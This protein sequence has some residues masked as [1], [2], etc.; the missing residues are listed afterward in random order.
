MLNTNIDSLRKFKSIVQSYGHNQW[1]KD[2][3]LKSDLKQ[4]LNDLLP[5]I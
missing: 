4:E 2:Y 3:H 5:S 1:E